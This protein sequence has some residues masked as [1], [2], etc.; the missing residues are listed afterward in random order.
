ML[1]RT[2]RGWRPEALL[3][4][5]TSVAARR[6]VTVAASANRQTEL[7]SMPA[8]N[9]PPAVDTTAAV[10]V[11]AGCQ[12]DLRRHA[13]KDSWLQRHS[14]ELPQQWLAFSD[15]HV[16]PKTLGTCLQVLERVH[17]EAS[18]RGAGILFLGEWCCGGKRRRLAFH[19]FRALV[20][21]ISSCPPALLCGE[22]MLARCHLILLGLPDVAI[23]AAWWSQHCSRRAY[24]C[25][26]WC[27]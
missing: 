8:D 11:D 3:P 4:C 25:C 22:S 5:V 7:D 19:P 24:C 16:S 27:R 9:E 21:F 14:P 1:L 12:V 17:E 10:G 15:L 2:A 6:S 18:R 23:M 26:C 20:L 13:P